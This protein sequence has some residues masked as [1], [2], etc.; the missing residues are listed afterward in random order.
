MNI[1]ECQQNNTVR[2][3]QYYKQETR[4][5]LNGFVTGKKPG[6]FIRQDPVQL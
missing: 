4:E 6:P 3:R 5:P 2:F 1:S